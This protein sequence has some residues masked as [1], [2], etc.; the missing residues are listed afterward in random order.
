MIRPKSWV[1]DAVVGPETLSDVRQALA[2][3]WSAHPEEPDRVRAE[4]AIATGEIAR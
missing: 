2:E 1:W 3:V 4:I